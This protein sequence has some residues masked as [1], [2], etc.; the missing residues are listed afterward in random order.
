MI[1]GFYGW[2]QMGFREWIIPQDKRFFQLLGEESRKVVECSGEV[3]EFFHNGG[4]TEAAQK[5]KHMEKDC[6]LTVHQI[7]DNLNQTFITPLD[8]EDISALSVLMDDIVDAG[9]D[10]V[11]RATL[12][13][14]ESKPEEMK[15][16]SAKLHEASL[17][18]STAITCLDGFKLGQIEPCLRKISQIQDESKDVLNA[19]LVKL[20]RENKPVDIIKAKEIYDD[21]A[22]AVEKC[23]DVASVLNDVLVKHR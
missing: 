18:V 9:Y 5:L 2:E 1:T 12:Y 10:A 20:F 6:D 15:L 7:F 23:E 14:I 21:L 8:Q 19:G 3:R 22:L 13:E 11:N 17:E 4:S 16:L